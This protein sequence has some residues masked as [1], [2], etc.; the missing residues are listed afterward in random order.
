[1]DDALDSPEW[2]SWSNAGAQIL[3]LTTPSWGSGSF[4]FFFFNLV[5]SFLMLFHPKLLSKL[6]QQITF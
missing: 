1:M 5:T 3:L 4:F 2:T 6:M